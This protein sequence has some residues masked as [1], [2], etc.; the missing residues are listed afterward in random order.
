MTPGEVSEAITAGRVDHLL[1]ATAGAAGVSERR[2]LLAA[3]ERALRL[4]D[5]GALDEALLERA[6]EAGADDSTLR[7]DGAAP[8]PHAVLVPFVVEASAK[9]FVRAMFVTYL[10]AG[11][12]PAAPALSERSRVAVDEAVE[13][14]ARWAGCTPRPLHLVAAQPEALRGVRVRGGSLAAAA[15]VSA[16]SFLSERPV[17]PGT[18]VTGVVLGGRIGP[19][20]RL[21]EKLDGALR[22]RADVRR[23]VVPSADLDPL[24]PMRPR[25]VE[26]VGVSTVDELLDVCLDAEVPTERDPERRVEDAFRL[27]RGGWRGWRWPGMRERL[28]R[29]SG[30][31]PSG[32]PDL[33]VRTLTMLGA[34]VRHLGAPADSLAIL[35]RAEEVLRTRDGDE[36]VP[37]AERSFLHRNLSMTLRQLC[38]LREAT[39]AADRAVRDAR[40]GRLRGDLFTSLGCAGL[41]AS[42][43][44]RPARAVAHHREAF[45]LARVHSPAAAPRSAA[46]LIEA[47]GQSGDIAAARDV[48]GATIGGEEPARR[49]D[50][51][52]W[53]RVCF[54]AALYRAG[55]ADDAASVLDDDRVDHAIE[56]APLPGLWARRWRA[57]AR[58][59]GRACDS[60]FEQLAASPVAHGPVLEPHV[61]FLAHLNV[62]YEARARLAHGAWDAD[63]AARAGSALQ[64][65]PAHG[66]VPALLGAPAAAVAQSLGEADRRPRSTAR[67]LDRLLARCARLE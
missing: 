12:V 44:G 30:T 37:Y 65:L 13:L 21:R 51:Q 34:V 14:A 62:L 3:L 52:V 27:Y 48:F 49:S 11:R 55:L 20:G 40:R 24:R 67:A 31:L 59:H 8:P 28:E 60:A 54:A 35:R 19:V 9:G 41:V 23:L 66:R 29:L 56:Q 10:P 39:A 64:R 43:R 61:A 45:E 6:R 36:A 38:H 2:W 5:P 17:R 16:A 25:G 42:S 53:I 32:R 15:L 18:A 50:Q 57:L 1:R 46:Y 22:G 47:L 4:A 33:Q 7:P 26:L 58:C 63:A